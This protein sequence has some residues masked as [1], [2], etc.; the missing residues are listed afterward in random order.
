MTMLGNAK[1]LITVEVLES[2]N[3][4][5]NERLT[6]VVA[7]V[8]DEVPLA[9]VLA[10]KC[11]VPESRLQLGM[12]TIVLK[13]VPPLNKVGS[14]N[15]YACAKVGPYLMIVTIVLNRLKMLDRFWTSYWTLV[16]SQRA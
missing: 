14:L 15:R 6:L 13:V 10:L 2:S 1:S 5:R 8:G 7:I 11:L 9:V 12:V 16:P 4:R 3:L